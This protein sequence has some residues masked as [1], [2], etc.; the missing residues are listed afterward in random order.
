[1]IQSRQFIMVFTPCILN[2]G[3]STNRHVGKTRHLGSVYF[4]IF[5]SLSVAASISSLVLKDKSNSFSAINANNAWKENTIQKKRHP[6]FSCHWLS[7]Q[8]RCRAERAARAVVFHAG[9]PSCDSAVSE[10][11]GVLAGGGWQEG[12][13]VV[14]K[15]SLFPEGSLQCSNS[16]LIGQQVTRQPGTLSARWP[17]E[18]ERETRGGE[19]YD[20]QFVTIYNL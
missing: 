2:E 14:I 8:T 7:T 15:L 9:V 3:P 10:T 4:S 17:L 16:A 11:F 1:M 13:G 18:R 19:F 20:F 6:L 12:L 5:H